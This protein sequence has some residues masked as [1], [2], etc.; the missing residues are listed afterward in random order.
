MSD[1]P[2]KE[3][4]LSRGEQTYDIRSTKAQNTEFYCKITIP[5]NRDDQ[6]KKKEL[7]FQWRPNGSSKIN[8]NIDETHPF[9]MSFPTAKLELKYKISNEKRWH[10]EL[11]NN[12]SRHLLPSTEK[13][14]KKKLSKKV[15]SERKEAL[16]LWKKSSLQVGTPIGIAQASGSGIIMP[17]E[18]SRSVGL[19]T[20]K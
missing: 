12:L 16:E 1:G 5:F 18:R 8:E 17:S 19:S 4:D 11:N 20:K 15:I 14:Q 10:M 13:E 6:D 2:E 3:E 7:I 9:F